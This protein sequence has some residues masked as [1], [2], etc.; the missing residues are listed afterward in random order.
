MVHGEHVL[1]HTLYALFTIHFNFWAMKTSLTCPIILLSGSYITSTVLIVRS[2][3]LQWVGFSTVLKIC[4]GIYNAACS[5]AFTQ[6]Q[7]L[8][9][10][11]QRLS[12]FIIKLTQRQIQHT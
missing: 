6:T 2:L 10:S 11:V 1:P 5:Q 4:I 9:S 12:S 7:S 3:I 8:P